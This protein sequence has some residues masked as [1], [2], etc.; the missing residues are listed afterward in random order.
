MAALTL[1]LPSTSLAATRP[2]S[3]VEA[4]PV[5]L[6]AILDAHLRRTDGQDRVFGTLLGVRREHDNTVEVRS[7]FAV[8]Y[9]V[10]GVGQ[11]TIDMDH[12]RA[13][14][15]LHTKVTP[16]EAV[17]GWFATHRD[18]N[19]FSALIHNFYS[20]EAS[21]FP[22]V[23]L[24]LDPASLAFA[25][26]TAQALGA[27]P[28]H[29]QESAG[30]HLAFVPVET[31][32]VVHEHER[33]SLDLL[34]HN[35]AALGSALP[36][37]PTPATVQPDYPVPSPL[38]T[39]AELLRS[40][41]LMLDEVLEYVRAVAAG[42]RQG[43]EKVGRAL[44]ETVGSV[45]APATKAPGA[46]AAAA[47]GADEQQQ[48]GEKKAVE[49]AQKDFEEEFNAHLADVLMVSYLANVIKTQAELSSRL[50]LV[51]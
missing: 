21:P 22:A 32:L 29:A 26:F 43:D 18:L 31:G 36:A 47:K 28:V 45:P 2:V 48:Q 15:E 50:N 24:T 34:S 38:A 6:A 5:V 27:R 12:H 1:N 10:R 25:A 49:G 42:E 17:V 35:L 13:L 9:E 41:A 33:P 40:V 20:Q 14:V 7:A 3:R 23:H 8:P 16:R 51:V 46:A 37:P 4:H 19:S 39:L 30:A 44:L 11:V